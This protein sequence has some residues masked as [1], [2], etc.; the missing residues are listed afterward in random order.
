MLIGVVGVLGFVAV[1]PLLESIKKIDIL[2]KK[3]AELQEGQKTQKEYVDYFEMIKWNWYWEKK[4]ILAFRY[5]DFAT[6]CEAPAGLGAMDMRIN[7]VKEIPCDVIN[8]NKFDRWNVQIKNIVN[9]GQF[10]T[11]EDILKS[12]DMEGSERVYIDRSGGKPFGIGEIPKDYVSDWFSVKRNGM[13]MIVLFYPA[14]SDFESPVTV[15]KIS[16]G[17]YDKNPK[18][19]AQSREFTGFGPVIDL[20]IDSIQFP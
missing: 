6:L 20:I 5:P 14:V 2:E 13:H 7:F 18:L 10:K 11:I 12:E 1:R 17:Q 15:I 19:S 16:G 8:D 4:D 3:V 9:H